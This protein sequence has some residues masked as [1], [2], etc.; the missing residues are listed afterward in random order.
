MSRNYYKAA[1]IIYSV[2]LFLLAVLVPG[3]LVEE[4]G[5]FPRS[6]ALLHNVLRVIIFILC[7]LSIFVIRQLYIS[8]LRAQKHKL[9]LLKIKNIEEQ[10]RIYRQ[11]RHDLYNHLTVISGL[12]QLGKLDS[13]RSYL[14]SYLDNYNKSIVTVNTGL[15]ELDIL[16][17][18]KISQAKD[19][20]IEVEYHWEESVECCQGQIV[21]IVS[22]MANAL[23]NAIRACEKANERKAMEVKIS[24]DPVDYIIEISNTYDTEIDLE[25]K[26][27][28]EGFTTK[29]DSPRGEGL[30]I[31]RKAVGKLKGHMGFSINNGYCH[32]KIEIPKLFLEGKA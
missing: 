13:L 10:N 14:S 2:Q 22:L 11:H 27:Q 12:A 26:L 31:M 7:I 32:L 8:S 30:S 6:S 23:D 1:I 4:V 16:L 15:K 5:I 3:N 9:E 18:A 20:G 24:G 28:I 19:K 17:F 29:P 21:R 25:S